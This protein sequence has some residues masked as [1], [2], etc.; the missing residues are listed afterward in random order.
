MTPTD[1]KKGNEEIA[2]K[3]ADRIGSEAVD[4]SGHVF[5]YLR[6]IMLIKEA[7]EAKDAGKK[8]LEDEVKKRYQSM[9]ICELGAENQSVMDYMKHW[10]GR[11]EKAEAENAKLKEEFARIRR[12]AQYML[13]DDEENQLSIDLNN[14]GRWMIHLLD[15]GSYPS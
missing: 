2:T 3:L 9:S 4:L 11:A 6:V 1:R 15:G 13:E 14:A 5:D 10:E 12:H 7:L 8:A